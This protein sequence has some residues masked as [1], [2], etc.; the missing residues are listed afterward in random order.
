M[1]W[2]HRRGENPRTLTTE[3]AP[4]KVTNLSIN[5]FAPISEDLARYNKIML[6]FVISGKSGIRHC[7]TC[8]ETH[9]SDICGT[10]E[11]A[12]SFRY[13]SEKKLK[14]VN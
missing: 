1:V 10:P 4:K 7:F 11:G 3:L 8:V 14:Q 5:I 6:K 2:Q 12:F 9:V 13:L